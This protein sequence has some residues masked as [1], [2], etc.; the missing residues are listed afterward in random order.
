MAEGQVARV[1][2]LS[3]GL[4][5]STRGEVEGEEPKRGSLHSDV[6]FHRKAREHHAGG[7]QVSA[8]RE[9]DSDSS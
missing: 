5:L 4:R 3:Q 7:H 8:G 1:A 9:D 2:Q 6:G